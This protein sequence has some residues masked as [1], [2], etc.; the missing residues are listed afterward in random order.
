MD[1]QWISALTAL[2]AVIVSPVVSV[3]VVKKQITANV[4]SVNRQ[5]WIADLRDQ[6]SELITLIMFINLNQAKEEVILTKFERAYLTETKINLLINPREKDHIQ[7]TKLIRS[8]IEEI[9]KEK[10]EKDSKRL[11]EI[12]DSIISLS[13]DILKREWERVKTGK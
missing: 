3:Y 8:A 4:V 1:A 12:R 5:K 9:F 6:I 11:I 10:A 2:V 7:L 13:Q